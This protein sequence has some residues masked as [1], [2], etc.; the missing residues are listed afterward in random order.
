MEANKEV[1]K[2]SAAPHLKHIYGAAESHPVCIFRGE[3]LVM[4][5]APNVADVT[6]TSPRKAIH[7]Q[8]LK[9]TICVYVQ[10][11]KKR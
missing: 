4:M 3:T 1:S 11:F 6:D 10:T 2:M 9:S 7:I 5:K 8:C